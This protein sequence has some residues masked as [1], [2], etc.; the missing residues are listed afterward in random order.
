[1]SNGTAAL[2]ALSVLGAGFIDP[3]YVV[4]DQDR[5]IEYNA[6]FHALF[7]RAVGRK[8]K[9]Q[10]CRDALSMSA[11]AGEKCLRKTCQS[12][13]AIRLDEVEA[14]IGETEYRLV[15]SAV[16]LDLGQ[17]KIGALIVLRDVT[18]EARVLERYQELMEA[19][20]AKRREL[21]DQLDARTRDLLLANHELNRLEQELARLKRGGT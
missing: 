4:D 8:L 16:P 5:I 12:T 10:T 11:C 20:E 1:M 2:Q 17:G 6:A 14:K 18:D 15:L 19:V 9:T 13:G 3:W 7:P 21:Q